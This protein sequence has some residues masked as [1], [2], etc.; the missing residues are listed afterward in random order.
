MIIL[1]IS[2][3]QR[4]KEQPS[5]V[6]QSATHQPQDISGSSMEQQGKTAV[7]A[8]QQLTPKIKLMS[9]MLGGIHVLEQIHWEMDLLREHSS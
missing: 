9:G 8:Y 4:D 3:Y 1:K 5:L 7:D 6:K 2:P